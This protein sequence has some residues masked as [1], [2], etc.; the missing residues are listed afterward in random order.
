MGYKTNLASLAIKDLITQP[1]EQ[2]L[3]ALYQTELICRKDLDNSED[4]LVEK[5]ISVADRAMDDPDIKIALDGA[6]KAM[7]WLGKGKKASTTIFANNAQVN[8]I[9]NDPKQKEHI[10]ASLRDISRLTEGTKIDH[11]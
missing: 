3:D 11:K 10:L 4:A 6:N 8:Q 9:E 5:A 7:A 2:A 1:S